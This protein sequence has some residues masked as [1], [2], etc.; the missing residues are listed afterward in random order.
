MT[1]APLGHARRAL[2]APNVDSGEAEKGTDEMDEGLEG[3]GR[4]G[5]RGM[6]GY[7]P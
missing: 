1:W 3:R 7:T 4:T 6:Q 5:E 2:S